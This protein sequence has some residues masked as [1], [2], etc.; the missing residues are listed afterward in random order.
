MYK[1]TVGSKAQVYHGTA[2]HTSGGLTKKNL[3]KSKGRI[4]SKKQV[5]HGKKAI[6]NLRKLGFVAKKGTFRL[7]KKSDGKKKRGKTEKKR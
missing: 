7:F 5:A 6:K 4:K 2:K 1:N 3:V